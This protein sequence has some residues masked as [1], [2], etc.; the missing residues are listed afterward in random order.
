[1]A[2]ALVIVR[3]WLGGSLG[4]AGLLAVE[5]VLGAVVYVLA[6]W[7]FDRALLADM[8]GFAMHALPGGERVVRRAGS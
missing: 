6:L 7:L 3:F 5:I 1:M 2:V 8:V 4:Q